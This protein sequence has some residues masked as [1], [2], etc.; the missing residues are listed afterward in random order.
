MD[1]P[2]S[3]ITELG[4][5]TLQIRAES[6]WSEIGVTVPPS[7]ALALR[8]AL[9]MTTT[10]PHSPCPTVATGRALAEAWHARHAR[11]TPSEIRTWL[12]AHGIAHEVPFVEL[13]GIEDL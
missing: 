8:A 10:A 6:R 2:T 7:S 5:G 13:P 9:G 11:S 4:D 1:Q 12:D 3:S